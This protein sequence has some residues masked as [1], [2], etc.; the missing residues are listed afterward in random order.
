[1]DNVSDAT[2]FMILFFFKT[3][4]LIDVSISGKHRLFHKV[5]SQDKGIYIGHAQIDLSI[6][7]PHI[8][9]KGYQV[10]PNR[11]FDHVSTY[12]E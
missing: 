9:T 8:L 7:Y 12:T 11:P 10:C 4:P 5:S 6:T 3:L 2:Y 1:M